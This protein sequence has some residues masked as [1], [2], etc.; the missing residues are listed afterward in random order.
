MSIAFLIIDMQ[1]AF[2][3]NPKSCGSIQDAL[4]YINETSKLFRE[5]KM[6]VILIQDEEAGEGPES[7]GYAL[8]DQ[9]LVEESDYR[10][11]KFHSNAFWDTG[12]E[13]LLKKLEVEFLVISGFAAEYCVLFTYNGAVERNYNVSILQ[14]GIGG[15]DPMQIKETHHIRPSISYEAVQYILS[16]INKA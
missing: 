1:K 2:V 10:I 16:T 4:E 11:S 13:A 14:H 6:P 8:M 5:A 3:D 15:F 7:E 12:L 9:L